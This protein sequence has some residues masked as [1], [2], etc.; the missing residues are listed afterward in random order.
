MKVHRFEDANQF[1]ARVKDYLLSQEALYNLLLGMCHALIHNPER[2]DQE[3]YLATV[4][5]DG[6][7]LA[8]A[9]RTPPRNLVLSQ[10]HDLKAVEALTQDLHISTKSLPGVIAPINEAQAFALAWHSLTN[11]SYELELALR[12]FQLQKVNHLSQAISQ[13]KGYLRQATETDRELLV[14]WYTAFS[15]EAL[16]SVELDAERWVERVL[17]QGSVYLW[18][19]EFPV[20]IACRGSLTPNGVRVGMVYT[21]PEYRRQGYASACVAALSQTLLNQGHRFCFLFTDL[22]NPTANHIYQEIGYQSVGDWHQY[23]FV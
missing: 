18:Q 5:V 22:A 19:D 4:E 2:F 9:M 12:T 11:Q 16:G 23:S 13:A 21:P 20:S 14:N 6:N 15:L 7:I 1:Y 3:L 17:Q 8:V 10:I